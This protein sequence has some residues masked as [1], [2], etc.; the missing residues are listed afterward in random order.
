MI[1][2]ARGELIDKDD[3]KI[4]FTA[5]DIARVKANQ[6]ALIPYSF[7]ALVASG[8]TI[9][10]VRRYL[11]GLIDAGFGGQVDPAFRDELSTCLAVAFD[12]LICYDPLETT[13]TVQY[14]YDFDA[15]LGAAADQPLEAFRA[16]APVTCVYQIEQGIAE[17]L[18]RATAGTGTLV[19]AI[20]RVRL[21]IIGTVVGDRVFCYRRMT[22]AADERDRHESVSSAHANLATRQ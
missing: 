16:N 8:D 14:P 11:Q 22:T 18:G 3:V 20:Y 17:A 19:E 5:E 10:D 1:A 7:C 9:A 2:G 13:K 15:W 21:N 4:R 6:L 12:K